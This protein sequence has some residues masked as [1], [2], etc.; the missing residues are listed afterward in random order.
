MATGFTVTLLWLLLV[1][2]KEA[3]AIG[4]VKLLAGGKPSL[5]DGMHNWPEVDPVVIALPLSILVAVAVSLFTRPPDAAHL[6]TCFG[7][8]VARRNS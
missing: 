7:R 1:K 3:G 4:L 8:S 5:L 2:A 6:E